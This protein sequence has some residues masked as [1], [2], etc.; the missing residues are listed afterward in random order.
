MGWTVCIWKSVNCISTVSARKGFGCMF[1][2]TSISDEP[3]ESIWEQ[4]RGAK[5]GCCAGSPP[6]CFLNLTKF[7]GRLDI[8]ECHCDCCSELP[9]EYL[10][11]HFSHKIWNVAWF[12]KKI[13][14]LA[15]AEPQLHTLSLGAQ[16][17]IIPP[18]WGGFSDESP[19]LS[20]E[21]LD[22]IFRLSSRKTVSQYMWSKE[23]VIHTLQVLVHQI[24]WVTTVPSSCSSEHNFCSLV[25]SGAQFLQESKAW[26]GCFHTEKSGSV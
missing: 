1:F 21:G 14:L 23:T 13:N 3:L 17:W 10:N 19:V 5:F 26:A 15:G 22:H 24:L 25:H 11:G 12:G 6:S 20:H 18:L 4:K 9:A 2:N 16:H 8:D 7:M